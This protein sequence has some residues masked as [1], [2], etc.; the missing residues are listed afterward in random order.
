MDTQFTTLTRSYHDNYLQYALTGNSTYQTAY[1]NAKDGLDTIISSLQSEVDEQES[2]ISNFYKS[3]VEGKLRDL[4]SQEKRAKRE[5]VTQ[6]DKNI[7]ARMRQV[8]TASPITQDYTYYY[9]AIGGLT[10]AIAVL[11]ML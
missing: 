2:T 7:T 4:N 6:N 11:R 1:E 8:P 3:D 10:L 9:V 5:L